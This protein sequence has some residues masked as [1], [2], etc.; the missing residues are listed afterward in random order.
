MKTGRM[1]S[2]L[3]VSLLIVFGRAG[4]AHGSERTLNLSVDQAVS[5]AL[6]ENLG[7][8][9][10]KSEVAGAQGAVLLEKGV[11][12][13]R[14]EAGVAAQDQR[15]TSLM[16]GE[17][18]KEKGAQW[19]AAIRKKLVTG[20]EIGLVWENRRL[21]TDSTLVIF[22]PSYRS[23]LA[24]TVSQQLMKGNSKAAQ[25]AGIRAAEKI[26]AA[27]SH[28]VEN[29]AADLAAQVKKTYWE[30]AFARQ[31][32]EV[33]ELSLKLARNLWEET[34]SKINNEVLARVEI[35][36]PESEIARREE[37][38]IA[39]E[40]HL[41]ATEDDLKLLLNNRDWHVSFVPVDVFE[42]P[43]REPDLQTVLANALAK[44]P[45]ILATDLQ[46]DAAGVMVAK[47]Q[48]DLRPALALVGAAGITGVGDDYQDSLD[49][50]L[51]DPN[52][53]WQIGLKLQLPIG[54]SSSRGLLAKAAAELS[55]SRARAEILR[56]DA[57]KTA[58]SAVREVLL[59]IKTIEATRKTSLAAEKMLE[60]EQEKFH[61]G[62]ATA[63]DVLV[64]QESYAQALA[65]EKRALV[66]LAKAQAELERIQGLVSFGRT[67]RRDPTHHESADLVC[68]NR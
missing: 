60:A 39:A 4:A 66:D 46:V 32:I 64:S 33:K 8:Q 53:S 28:L 54:N 45:D 15:M 18:E 62:L 36:Q 61:I 41:A 25:T 27:A 68:R 20:T 63:N 58:R 21:E 55:K 67:V 17:E 31:D 12:D 35:F 24:V 47:A 3:A 16:T 22:D 30:L 44:R 50:A 14:L 1:P 6:A 19:D 23:G 37:R 2:A 10:Q 59:A 43:S 40:K 7:L 48:D 51:S 57:E 42:I 26:T 9:L 65:G 56:R 52:I 29:Q 49:T 34:N 11:F 13:S 38:L 5:M